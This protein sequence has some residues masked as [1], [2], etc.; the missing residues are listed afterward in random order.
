MT[1]VTPH[2]GQMPR[3]AESLDRIGR[4]IL[5]ELQRNATIPIA[6]LAEPVGLSQTPY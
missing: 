1:P 3:G 4:K 6:Q 2:G 5:F